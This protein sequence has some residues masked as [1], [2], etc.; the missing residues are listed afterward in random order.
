MEKLKKK[1]HLKHLEVD[2]RIMYKLIKKVK[3]YDLGRIHMAEDKRRLWAAVKTLIFF[4]LQKM[5]R[6]F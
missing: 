3:L 1:S 2:G 4:Q 6:N 5:R